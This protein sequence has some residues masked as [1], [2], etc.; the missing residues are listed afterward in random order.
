MSM[1]VIA[2][3]CLLVFMCSF[4]CFLVLGSSGLGS[5]ALCHSRAR[6]SLLLISC[7]VSMTVI[8]TIHYYHHY[9]YNYVHYSNSYYY[10]YYG[11]YD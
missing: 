3:L 8:I 5:S 11:C 4:Y 10:C 1:L 7:I 9:H 2:V 6:A